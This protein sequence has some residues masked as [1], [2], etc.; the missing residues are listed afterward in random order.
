MS[1]CPQNI[2]TLKIAKGNKNYLS[3]TRLK[4]LSDGLIF[5]DISD[6]KLFFYNNIDN[7]SAWRN[8]II[9]ELSNIDLSKNVTVHGNFTCIN[10]S[11]F[12]TLNVVDICLT[13]IYAIDSSVNFEITE[14]A[15][16]RWNHEKAH[17]SKLK[18]S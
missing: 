14:T 4:D 6:K 12:N 8:I 11:S 9:N 2:P 1:G 16:T 17:C 15:D 5:Y 18:T 7:K 3:T 10:E 13:N